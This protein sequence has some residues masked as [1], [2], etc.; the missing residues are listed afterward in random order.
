MKDQIYT[1]VSNTTT[2]TAAAKNVYL[3]S[4]IRTVRKQL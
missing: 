2:T 3:E 4:L 1:S